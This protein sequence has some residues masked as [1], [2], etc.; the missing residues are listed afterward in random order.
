LQISPF[1]RYFSKVLPFYDS[2]DSCLSQRNIWGTFFHQPWIGADFYTNP[3]I[4]FEYDRNT[5][6]V[7]RQKK[8]GG[9]CAVFF[10]TKS[11]PKLCY[12]IK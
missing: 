4:L 9:F 5:P 2:I 12:G 1:F 8:Q 6:E 3:G 10:F 7:W 11:F